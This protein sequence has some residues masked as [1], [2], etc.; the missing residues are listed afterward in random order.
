VWDEAK[1]ASDDVDWTG[2]YNQDTWASVQ[3]LADV[4]EGQTDITAETVTQAMNG[5]TS[6]DAGGLM[7]PID[8]TTEFAVPGLNRVFNRMVVYTTA[9]DGEVVQE[10][11][12]E[13]LGPFFGQ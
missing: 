8:F 3:V 6:I 9:K 1:A 7:A 12:F 13:D 2:P 5:A 10:G 4:L 11:G